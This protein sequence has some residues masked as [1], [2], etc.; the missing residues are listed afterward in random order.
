MVMDDPESFMRTCSRNILRARQVTNTQ[1]PMPR[2]A[3]IANMPTAMRM[4]FRALPPDFAG[5]VAATGA[6]GTEAMAGG[7]TEADDAG[8]TGGGAGRA[9]L[10]VPSA[11]PHPTQ[12]FML[13]SFGEPQLVQNLV[14]IYPPSGRAHS[15]MS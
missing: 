13:S 11:V 1:L 9:A 12:N 7:E 8:L 3:S 14:A 6:A 2:T 15:H 4:N 10:S 5:G